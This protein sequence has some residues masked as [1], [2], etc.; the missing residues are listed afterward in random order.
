M[1]VGEICARDVVT[2]TRDATVLDA[3]RRM[4]ERHVGAVVVVEGVPARPVGVLTDR[5]I[6]VGIVAQGVEDIA[7]LLVGDVLVRGDE[8][9]VTAYEGDS[10][11]WTAWQ[12]RDA[13]VRRV[14]VIDKDG[15][16]VGIL[17]LDDLLQMFVEQ[18]TDL[19]E[20]IRG[21]QLKESR[22]RV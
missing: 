14:P 10:A 7:G 17:P 20:V 2:V 6:A 12:M 19:V 4:R 8:E 11:L 9:V 16:L 21:Q 22:D 15:N 3:A 1:D 18:L 13:G 5:D